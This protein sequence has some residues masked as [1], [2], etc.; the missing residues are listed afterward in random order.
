[1]YAKSLH[2]EQE[3]IRVYVYTCVLVVFELHMLI[4]YNVEYNKRK[5]KIN[6]KIFWFLWQ[7]T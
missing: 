1:M 7:D 5:I 6:L 4:G 2:N 3:C